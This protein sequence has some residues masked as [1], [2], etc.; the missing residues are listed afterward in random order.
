VVVAVGALDAKEAAGEVAAA[1]A[2]AKGGFAGGVKRAEVFRAARIVARRER[3]ERIV[4]ALR[5]GRAA[6][7]TWPV[8]AGHTS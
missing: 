2:V 8:L 5:K 4:E 3:F 6:G 1:Q 7:M